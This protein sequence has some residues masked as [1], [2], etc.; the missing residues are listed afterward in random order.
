LVK[1][2]RLIDAAFGI[3]CTYYG[4]RFQSVAFQNVPPAYVDFLREP[5]LASPVAPLGRVARGEAFALVSDLAAEEYHE[6]A[7]LLVR[8]GLSLAGFRTVLAVPLRKD[9]S[10]LGAITIYRRGGPP[11]FRNNKPVLSRPPAPAGRPH[12]ESRRPR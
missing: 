2:T 9:A 7:G 10:L 12:R 4:E 6:R 3:L 5:Q 1:A 11:F 8:Q